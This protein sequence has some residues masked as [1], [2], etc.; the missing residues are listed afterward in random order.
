MR[1]IVKE[2]RGYPTGYL[3]AQSGAIKYDREQ[4]ELK[5]GREQ[6]ETIFGYTNIYN[7]TI[8]TLRNHHSIT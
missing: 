8:P 2:T 3:R 4:H 5:A 7:D 6:D 1:I